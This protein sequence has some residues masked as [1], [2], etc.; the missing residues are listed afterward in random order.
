M[1]QFESMATGTPVLGM[2]MGSVPEVI[3]HGQTGFIC[4]S[5]EEMGTLIPAALELDR[6][7]CRDRVLS[8]FSVNK[9]V[10]GY[11]AAYQQVLEGRISNINCYL[12]DPHVPA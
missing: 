5:Y 10:D 8:N 2:N 4:E 11:E 1:A 6:Q 3:A 7:K 9:M 12:L